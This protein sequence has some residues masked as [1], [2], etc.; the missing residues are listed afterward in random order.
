MCGARPSGRRPRGHLVTIGTA[1]QEVGAGL[2]GGNII[3]DEL[4]LADGPPVPIYAAEAPTATVCS[5][6]RMTPVPE[7]RCDGTGRRAGRPVVLTNTARA[8]CRHQFATGPDHRATTGCWPGRRSVRARWPG[9]GPTPNR[10]FV[11]RYEPHETSSAWTDHTVG[12][13][14]E[15]QDIHQYSPRRIESIDNGDPITS[16][17]TARRRPHDPSSRDMLQP[18]SSTATT[19]SNNGPSLRAGGTVWTPDRRTARSVPRLAQRR[20]P[21][22]A[23]PVGH[24]SP[25]AERLDDRWPETSL[26]SS[27][28]PL[29]VPTSSSLHHSRDEPPGGSAEPASAREVVAVGLGDTLRDS[30]AQPAAHL[31]RP[32]GRRTS[33]SVPLAVSSVHRGEMS[34]SCRTAISSLRR[35]GWA[36]LAADEAR[37]REHCDTTSC[38]ARCSRS[39][40]AAGSRPVRSTGRAAAGRLGV[41]R[42][43]SVGRLL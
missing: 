39:V 12:S 28:R 37:C 11:G 18:V 30:R 35:P 20:L 23:R 9:A 43:P 33:H 2:P 24:P 36:R 42:R 29:D 15:D 25:R 7:P 10:P 38:R 16:P 17:A 34:C 5:G 1:S 4:T 6:P 19:A 21:S 22:A 3:T 14:G 26:D 13:A 41:A 40:G 27:R 8:W 32:G 31:A